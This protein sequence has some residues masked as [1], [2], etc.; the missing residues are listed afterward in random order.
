[1]E[2][3]STTTLP[4]SHDHSAGELVKMLS[5]PVPEET[6]ASVRADA[7]EIRERTHR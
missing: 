3:P 7:E 1:M 4:N 2:R 6:V 5:E